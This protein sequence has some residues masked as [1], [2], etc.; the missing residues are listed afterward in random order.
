MY[1]SVRKIMN[2]LCVYLVFGREAKLM[3]MRH[4]DTKY[5]ENKKN[6][7]RYDQNTLQQRRQR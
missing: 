3:E 6:K 2:T 1:Q 4:C 7:L 5:M